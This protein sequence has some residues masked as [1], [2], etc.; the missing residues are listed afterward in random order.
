MLLQRLATAFRRQDWFTVILEVIIV[1]VGILI[2]LQVE[3]WNQDRRERNEAADWRRQILA[4]LRQTQRDLDGRR[5]YAA[6]ALAFGERALVLM[7]NDEPL[8]DDT[9]WDL[10]LGAFQ[11]GQIWPYR[12]TGPAFRQAQNAGGLGLVAEPDVIV[13]L[14]YLYDVAATDYE[15]ISGGLPKYRDLIRERL[16]WPL[17][18][19]IWD[20][21]CQVNVVDEGYADYRFELVRCEPPEDPE[22]IHAAAAMLRADA[23]LQDSLRGR[24]SQLKVGEASMGRLIERVANAT[25]ALEASP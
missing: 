1:V 10:V 22:L 15:L 14:A 8:D 16:P 11:A 5:N 25:Q 13:T 17:Q 20:A 12:L 18:D 3:N 23:A 21:D 19:H 6:Q 4:D 2:A 7:G 9:A 24:L